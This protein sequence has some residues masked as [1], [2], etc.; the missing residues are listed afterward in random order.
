MD[1]KIKIISCVIGVGLCFV[2]IIIGL[3]GYTFY[4]NRT[5][6]EGAPYNT[7]EATSATVMILGFLPILSVL[8]I[9]ICFERKEAFVAVSLTFLYAGFL[10]LIIGTLYDIW[11]LNLNII[12]YNTLYGIGFVCLAIGLIGVAKKRWEGKSRSS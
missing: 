2:C 4:F 1:E 10:L 8:C 9:I 5:G 6:G 3:V 11:S 7:L 12:L